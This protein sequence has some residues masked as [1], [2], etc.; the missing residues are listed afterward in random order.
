M[1]LFFRMEDNGILDEYAYSFLRSIFNTAQLIFYHCTLY[2]C[3]NVQCYPLILG[4]A[5]VR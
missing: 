4:P 1:I 5:K 2:H 3:K